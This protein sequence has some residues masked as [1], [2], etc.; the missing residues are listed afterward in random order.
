METPTFEIQIKEEIFDHISFRI[1]KIKKN[2]D[3]LKPEIN[4][5]MKNT[6][7]NFKF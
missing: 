7:N 6:I 1:N 3:F 4:E 5:R 2:F